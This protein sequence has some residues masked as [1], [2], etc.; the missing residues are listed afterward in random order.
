MIVGYLTAPR[1]TGGVI[2][3]V[4]GRSSSTRPVETLVM[5]FADLKGL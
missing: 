1:L 5:L 4:D 3:V 2:N